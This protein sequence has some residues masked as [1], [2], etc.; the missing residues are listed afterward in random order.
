M[1]IMKTKYGYHMFKS[2]QVDM[3]DFSFDYA[4]SD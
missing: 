2:F 1:N 3:F 4:K